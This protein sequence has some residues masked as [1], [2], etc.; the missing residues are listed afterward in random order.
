MRLL[1]SACLL[2]V[3]CRYDGKSIPCPAVLSLA[4]KHQL[5]PFCPEIY[6]GLPTPR[7]PAEAKD[8][9]VLDREGNDK[10]AQFV[11]GASEALRVYLL[12]DCEAAI[13]KSRSPSCGL[14]QIY[15]GSF[16][17]ALV[18]GSGF[19]AALFREEG[20]QVFDEEHIEEIPGI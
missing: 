8:G 14:H 2:G 18:P 17:G 16:T 6:G 11:R 12:A 7:P 13:L 19:T 10:T 3:P 4:K 1:V 20:I 15:D 9:R 5:V